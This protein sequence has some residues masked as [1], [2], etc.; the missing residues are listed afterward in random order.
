MPISSRWYTGIFSFLLPGLGQLYNQDFVK[1]ALFFTA[2]AVALFFQESHFFLP[3]LACGAGADAFRSGQEEPENG[4]RRSLYAAV[5]MVGVLAWMGVFVPSVHG[6]GTQMQ[7]NAAADRVA[8][9]VRKCQKRL[10]RYAVSLE[11]CLLNHE[12]KVDV[13]TMPFHLRIN[14]PDGF[15]LQSAGPDREFH[16]R[17]D[18]IFH[19][20]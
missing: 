3:I 18:Y 13:W 1:A 16:T 6:V 10:K 2:F 8:S 11:E 20:R 14:L 17:D 5:G 15:E 4:R 7:M 9:E 19:F 12:Q